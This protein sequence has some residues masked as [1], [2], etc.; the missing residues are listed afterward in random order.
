MRKSTQSFNPYKDKA[1]LNLALIEHC[2]ECERGALDAFIVR[3]LFPSLAIE[4]RNGRS[5]AFGECLVACC[6]L[7]WI[8]TPVYMSRALKLFSTSPW[9]WCY[10]CHVAI[11]LDIEFR[12]LAFIMSEALEYHIM[13]YF[14]PAGSDSYCA[15]MVSLSYL[16]KYVVAVLLQCS[17]LNLFPSS[18]P[19]PIRSHPS[20]AALQTY[21]HFAALISRPPALG[22][23]I[24]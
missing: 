4:V 19:S 11:P 22:N 2:Y 5:C 3:I 9:S 24:A 17:E 6:M 7:C 13:R 14:L 10:G 23:Q 1:G 16:P 20:S 21:I 15:A 12:Q 18:C 8:A